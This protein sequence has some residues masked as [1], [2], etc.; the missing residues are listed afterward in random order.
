MIYFGIDI[1]VLISSVA[2]SEVFCVW[3]D[4]SF[5]MTDPVGGVKRSGPG[6]GYKLPGGPNLVLDY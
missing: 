5:G 1:A 4:F 6:R 2:I 3:V